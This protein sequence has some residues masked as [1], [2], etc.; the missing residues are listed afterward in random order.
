MKQDSKDSRAAES[1]RMWPQIVPHEAC[2]A[3][4][5][6]ETLRKSLTG[7][8]GQVGTP[9]ATPPQHEGRG[10]ERLKEE[11][12]LINLNKQILQFTNLVKL[13]YR[14]T[15]HFSPDRC[16][17]NFFSLILSLQRLIG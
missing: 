14:K 12:Q 10:A 8:R 7:Y 9:E 6:P 11:S 16:T 17:T 15:R 1:L 4:P 5:V 3:K 13:F 2:W